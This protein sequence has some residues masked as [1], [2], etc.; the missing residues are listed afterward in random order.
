[1]PSKQ[2]S[3][4]GTVKALR[5]FVPAKDFARSRSFYEDLGFRTESLGAELAEMQLGLTPG[6]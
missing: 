4:A 1:M 2:G 6:A 3:R 5:P